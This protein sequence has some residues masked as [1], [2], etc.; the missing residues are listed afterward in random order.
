M[1]PMGSAGTGLLLTTG[2]RIGRWSLSEMDGKREE[3]PSTAAVPNRPLP[4]SAAA[5]GDDPAADGFANRMMENLMYK[6]LKLQAKHGSK[7]PASAAPAPPPPAAPPPPPPPH[8]LY[9]EEDDGRDRQHERSRIDE[10]ERDR[11]RDREYDHR[12]R[13]REHRDRD[14]DRSRD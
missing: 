10:R 12:D 7:Q 1:T 6:R 3:P 5:T 2:E 4:S 9:N 13:K 8:G 11:E 14:R